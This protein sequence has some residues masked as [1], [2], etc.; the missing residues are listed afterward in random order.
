[1]TEWVTGQ[2]SSRTGNS[3]PSNTRAIPMNYDGDILR[4]PRL[5]PPSTY[6]R[7]TVFHYASIELLHQHIVHCYP[8][9]RLIISYLTRLPVLIT[10]KLDC[11][12]MSNLTVAFGKFCDER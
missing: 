12:A 3:L 7:F 6:A 4:S 2:E 5:P 9:R 10:S 8:P 1:V 11:V